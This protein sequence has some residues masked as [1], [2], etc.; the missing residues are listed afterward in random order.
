MPTPTS[1]SKILPAR[2]SKAN[3][4]AALT[5]GDLLEGELCYAKDED[6]LYQVE[7]GVLVK[8][9]GGLQPG[10]NVSEL[11]NDAGYITDAGVTQIIAG[12]NVT[13]DPVGG[14]GAVTINAE[15]GGAQLLDDLQDVST[16]GVQNGQ[17]LQYNSTAGEWQ[18]VT[19]SPGSGI[20]EA[21][22]DGNYYVRQSGQWVNLEDAL[23]ALGIG[24]LGPDATV[25]GGDFISGLG[26]NSSFTLDAGNF[27]DGSS[28]GS[29]DATADGGEFT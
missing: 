11:V 29:N 15:P 8:A 19:I 16:S 5:A 10:D 6:A 22:E 14:T 3:L 7:A 9:G 12:D 25:E 2:G 18:P 23:A 13:V 4:D 20:E 24:G 26:G 17:F 28:N 21:P 27:G 1:R